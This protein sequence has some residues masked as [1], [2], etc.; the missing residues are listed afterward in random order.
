VKQKQAKELCP[1]SELQTVL[2]SKE[3]PGNFVLR[4]AKPQIL[5]LSFI[6]ILFVS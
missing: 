2:S 3:K 4:P 5:S 1:L 6:S